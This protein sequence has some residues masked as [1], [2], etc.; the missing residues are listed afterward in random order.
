MKTL[1]LIVALGAALASFDCTAQAETREM[2]TRPDVNGRPTKV[3][4]ARNFAECVANGMKLGYPRIGPNG[5]DDRRVAT[6]FCRS[7]FPQ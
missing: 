7:L 1:G 6:G 4:R 3:A 5:P 2:I